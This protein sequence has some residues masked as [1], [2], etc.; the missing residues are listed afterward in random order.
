MLVG[1]PEASQ[2]GLGHSIP[3][4][5]VRKSAMDIAQLKKKYG[6]L[7]CLMGNIDL[8][9]TL[10]RGTPEETEAEV[11][12]RILELGPGGGYILASSNGL[13]AYC[14]PENV[15]AMSRALLKYGY[16]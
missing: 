16:Y 8:H 14:K 11:K 9:Y 6:H 10:T 12:Q 15:L 3:A 1:G 2:K 7:I 5:V 13:T 4:N